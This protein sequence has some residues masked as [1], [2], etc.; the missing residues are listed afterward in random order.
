M[1]KIVKT[2]IVSSILFLA[3]GFGLQLSEPIERRSSHWPVVRKEHLEIHPECAA[4]GYIGEDNQVHHIDTYKH[5]PAKELDKNN[6]ITL[7][8]PKH[9]NH[10]F[11]IGHLYNFKCRNPNVVEDAKR[12]RE[13]LKCRI[14]D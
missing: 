3:T 14:C 1:H 8:G 10:H 6:L 12:F 4:C 2:G 9:R 5:N 13:M 11:I 7:C